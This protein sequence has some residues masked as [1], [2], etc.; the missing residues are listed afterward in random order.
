MRSLAPASFSYATLPPRQI[1][2]RTANSYRVN[3]ATDNGA[4]IMM[5]YLQFSS[6]SVYAPPVSSV[7]DGFYIY[8]MNAGTSGTVTFYTTPDWIDANWSTLTSFSI[9][10]GEG[11][12]FIASNSGQSNWFTSFSR[13]TKMYAESI[14][15]AWSRPVASGSTAVAIGTNSFATSSGSIAVGSQTQSSGVDSFAGGR[16]ANCA[17]N[18]SSAIGGNSAANGSYVPNAANGSVALGGSY[19]AGTDSM[20]AVSTNNTSTY[21]AN[22]IS[23]IALGYLSKATGSYATA[24]GPSS[25]ASGQGSLAIGGNGSV[26]ASALGAVAIGGGVVNAGANAAAQSSVAIGDWAHVPTVIGKYAFSSNGAYVQG[27]TQAGLLVCRAVTS[28]ATPTVMKTDTAAAS[29]TNQ[30]T[31][32]NNSA[33]AFDGLIVARQAASLGTSSAAWQISGLIRR[34]S[35]AATTILI[36]ST[37][38]AISNVPG[39]TITLSADTTNGAL[40]ITATGAVAA[41]V[42]WVATINTSEVIYA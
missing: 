39:W 34:E 6:A 29:T 16:A 22:G 37:V 2:R 25:V 30:Q 15:G 42:R 10:P 18:Y 41:N 38:T 28:D 11:V 32:P 24:I 27:G 21:G 5:N 14:Y 26:T 9:Y 7:P 4:I 8:I 1:I 33:Y 36:A 20:S 31:L 19:T 12:E 23:S 13:A 3:P 17:G 40:A 35:T